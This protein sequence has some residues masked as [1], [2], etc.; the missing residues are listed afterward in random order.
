VNGVNSWTS[1]DPEGLNEVVVSGG[2][3]GRSPTSAVGYFQRLLRKPNA[4]GSRIAHDVNWSNFIQA[5]ET[6]ILAR[7][8]T[9]HREL[10]W[11]FDEG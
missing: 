10:A 2:I 8:K 5:A 9:A 11:F 3:S 6:N 4:P 1:F 7:L